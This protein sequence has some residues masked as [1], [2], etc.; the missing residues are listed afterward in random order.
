MFMKLESIFYKNFFGFNFVNI[1]PGSY[2]VNFVLE[3]NFIKSKWVGKISKRIRSKF[4]DLD[5]RALLAFR[6]SELV[7]AGIPQTKIIAARRVNFPPEFIQPQDRID[8]KICITAYKGV[9]LE[10]FLKTNREDKLKNIAQIFENFV[11]NLWVG[12]YDRKNSDYVVNR[13]SFIFPIDYQLLGPGFSEN[14][15][16][17][18]G[19]Y[20][21]SYNF[22][23]PADTGCCLAP[24]FINEIKKNKN[25]DFFNLMVGRINKLSVK[26]IK[27][28]FRGLYFFKAET[29]ENLN[30]KFIEFLLSRRTRL[31]EKINDWIK[32]D[33][34]RKISI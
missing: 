30:E 22:N 26:S 13:D 19:A 12:N 34:L 25:I 29:K 7:G 27:R 2:N 28:A 4:T 14:D 21:R 23:D 1:I 31:E 10:E 11:F 20:A 5:S 33:Y 6:L 9:N 24:V 15:E 3:R 17:S 32:S 8:D 18:L 16:V